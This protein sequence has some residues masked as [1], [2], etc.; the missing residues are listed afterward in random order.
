MST[1]KTRWP[2]V[3]KATPE[4]R[5]TGPSPTMA[6]DATSRRSLGAAIKITGPFASKK[7]SLRG[8]LGHE[9]SIQFQEARLHR[10]PVVSA[11]EGGTTAGSHRSRF[12]GREH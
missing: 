12:R 2:C 4:Q 5:P 9:V 3:A 6:R 11:L 1:A 7:I 10:L 8:S